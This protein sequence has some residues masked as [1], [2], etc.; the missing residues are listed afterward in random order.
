[1]SIMKRL[2]EEYCEVIHPDD[3]EAQDDLMRRIVS[4]QT[5]VSLE[6]MESKVETARSRCDE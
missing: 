3:T 4:G 1:M 6:E 2:L 5:E